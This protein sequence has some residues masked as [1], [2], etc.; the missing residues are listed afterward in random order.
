MITLIRERSEN[1]LIRRVLLHTWDLNVKSI[2]AAFFWSICLIFLIQSSNLYFQSIAVAFGSLTSMLAA[3][4]AQ[5]PSKK[6]RLQSY[7]TN[8]V[9]KKVLLLNFFT[10]LLFCISLDNLTQ[11]QSDSTQLD[12]VYR[13]ISLTLFLFWIIEMVIYNTICI[14]SI[15]E[16]KDS[17]ITAYFF[18]YLKQNK[19]QSFTAVL[20][21]FALSPLIFVFCFVGLTLAQG[22]IN[23]TGYEL[24]DEVNGDSLDI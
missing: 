16:G 7:L 3:H 21:L 5:K 12:L 14:L 22:I 18:T 19:I 10:G 2:P 13:S 17:S 9:F 8:S 6:P 24:F 4:V 20:I 11:N 23:I 1:N 15:G